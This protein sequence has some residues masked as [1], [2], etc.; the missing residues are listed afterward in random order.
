[1][2]RKTLSLCAALTALLPSVGSA[3]LSALAATGWTQDIVINGTANYNTSVTSTM[4]NGLGNIQNWTW[5]EAGTYLNSS[6][7][8]QTF[9][10]LN[11]SVYTSLTGV[12]TFQFQPFTAN[13][14][15]FLTTTVTSPAVAAT[16]GTLTLTTP[17]SLSYFALYGATA[18]GPSAATVVFT[19]T[20]NSTSSTYTIASGTGIG[21]DWFTVNSTR[22]VNVGARSSL[23]SEDSY[24]RLFYQENTNIGISESVISLN[25]VDAAKTI[26]SV[27]VTNTGGG[28][29][30][31]MAI[32]GGSTIPETS[33]STL[34][35]LLGV[36][37]LLRRRR[38]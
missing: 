34:V 24:S 4:D 1:M 10:G 11:S 14:A 19:F 23:R 17:Q 36:A 3:A 6:G 38:N 13:N 12:G 32:S 25:S 28:K 35:G 16:S 21:S 15:L 18:N 29:M 9:Q 2:N 26:A 27:T 30:A 37:G 22:A 20:D 8:A 31:I 5:V 7:T 33:T